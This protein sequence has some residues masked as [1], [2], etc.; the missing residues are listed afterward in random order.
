[1]AAGVGQQARNQAR[2]PS[3]PSRCR[4]SHSWPRA[5]GIDLHRQHLQP[6][7]PDRHI[8]DAGHPQQPFID[9]P[10][11]QSWTGHSRDIVFEESP[12][13][14]TRLRPIRGQHEG[15]RCPGRELGKTMATRSWTNCRAC[16]RSVPRSNS[17]MIE[18]SWAT[19][20]ERMTCRPRQAGHGLLERHGDER[21]DFLGEQS[22]AR[23]LDLNQRRCKFGKDVDRHMIELGQAGD[24]QDHRGRNHDPSKTHARCDDRANHRSNTPMTITRPRPRRIRR[25]GVRERRPSPRCRWQSRL[26][27]EKC[28]PH[29]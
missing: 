28:G 7:A 20:F 1:M 10:I 4:G 16:M 17:S 13:I 12:I 29:S 21:L 25:L 14:I 24:H 19:D 11:G 18:E 8:G 6:L 5:F 27:I 2:R 3:S 15:R 22:C 26:T 9:L 23:R